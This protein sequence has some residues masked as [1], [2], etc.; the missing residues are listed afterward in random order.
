[1][2]RCNYAQNWIAYL[3]IHTQFQNR[4][5]LTLS[6]NPL[7]HRDMQIAPLIRRRHAI[8]PWDST[9]K[10]SQK[11]MTNYVFPMC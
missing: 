1:L 8:Q 11:R 3:A 6:A 5:D 10:G 9:Y 4:T 2:E 7:H